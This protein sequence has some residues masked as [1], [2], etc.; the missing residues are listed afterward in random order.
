MS[1]IPLRNIIVLLTLYTAV[2]HGITLNMQHMDVL[3][4]LN[5]LGYLA[6]LG[7]LLGTVFEHYLNNRQRLLHYAFM[8]YT[9]VTI[10]AWLFI[11]GDFTDPLGVSTKLVELLLIVFLWLHNERTQDAPVAEPLF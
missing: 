4:T 11:N 6:L 5:A 1:V 2:V 3:F 10:L 9:G 7:A 8:T